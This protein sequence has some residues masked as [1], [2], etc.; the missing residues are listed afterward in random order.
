MQAIQLVAILAKQ[1]S[2]FL[3]SPA[4]MNEVIFFEKC[5]STAAGILL[6]KLAQSKAL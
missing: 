4:R 2:R 3:Y 1:Q 6:V 5:K